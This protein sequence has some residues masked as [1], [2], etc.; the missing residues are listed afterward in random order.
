MRETFRT[1][2]INKARPLIYLLMLL[3]AWVLA[4]LLFVL[5][6]SYVSD[7]DMKTI[8]APMDIVSR[9]SLSG[10]ALE[11]PDSIDEIEKSNALAHIRFTPQ[12]SGHNDTINRPYAASY[13]ARASNN[14]PASYHPFLFIGA[15]QER[16]AALI[17]PNKYVNIS[18]NLLPANGNHLVLT[19]DDTQNYRPKASDLASRLSGYAY[20]FARTNS[21]N[22]DSLGA[23]YG[24]S[25]AAAQF[26]YRINPGQ[27][28]VIDA[29]LRAQ[30]ALSS[31]DRELAAGLRVKPT[32][33]FPIAVIAE[34]RFRPSSPD[35]YALY[36]AG[37]KS[38]IPL[39]ADFKLNTY[40]QAGIS[41]AGRDTLFFDGQIIAERSI[42]KNNDVEIL[43]GGGAWAGGQRGAQR[44]DIGPSVSIKISSGNKNYR[45]SGD[46][47]ERV[48]GGASPNS[49]AAITL[50][51][52]F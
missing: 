14:L 50:S 1:D 17:D 4:R 43:A 52:D 23:R 16:S 40:G 27:E 9:I 49:G 36:V 41:T 30:S 39:P 2:S 20:I 34:R 31:S 18:P 38:D 10:Q 51:T 8:I 15:M 13:F 3:S 32:A 28:V 45:I 5:S 42:H 33:K 21:G 26:S 12:L 25:Q 47:R 6:T 29:T 46:W 24:G 11:N 48:G 7:A 37:G 44:Y 22:A 35:G 19:K